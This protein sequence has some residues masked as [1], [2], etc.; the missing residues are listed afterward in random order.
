M[1]CQMICLIVKAR[2]ARWVT[3]SCIFTFR[4]MLTMKLHNCTNTSNHY[5]QIL[6]S[7]TPQI[8]QTITAQILQT[9]TAEILQSIIAQ[10]LQSITAQ[11]IQTITAQILQSITAQILQRKCQYS[12]AWVLAIKQVQSRRPS[13][14]QNYSCQ[15]YNNK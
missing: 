10:I 8:L 4:E 9:I 14:I 11:I 1:Q 13:L 7:I 15:G 6:Q 12:V 5:S 3:R 2:L